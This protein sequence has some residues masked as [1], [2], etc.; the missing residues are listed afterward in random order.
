MGRPGR[1]GRH[2]PDV[3]DGLNSI[4]GD[5][6]QNGV[7]LATVNQLST[8]DG[9]WHEG[10]DG[11]NGWAIPPASSR[12]TPDEWDAERFYQLLEDQVVPLYYARDERGV[13]T[14]WLMTMKHAMRVAGQQFTARRMLTQYVQQSYAPAMRGDGLPDDP[15]VA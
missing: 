3:R 1:G 13:P 12:A 14:G 5:L 2:G 4:S 9:W 15:P 10:Y 6:G 8:L 11:Q 7:I